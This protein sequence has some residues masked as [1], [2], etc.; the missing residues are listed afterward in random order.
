M[1]VKMTYKKDFPIFQK[2]K[3]LVYLDSAATSQKPKQV[4]DS[5]N[6]FYNDFNANINRGLYD[7]SIQSTEGYE[8][9]REKVAQF[10]GAS[11]DE[12]IFTSGTTDSLNKLARTL[13][14]LFHT[15]SEIVLTEMEHHSNIVPWQETSK[16]NKMKLKFIPLK[17]M[18][19]DYEIAEKIINDKTAIVSLTHLSNSL[20]TINNIEKIIELAKK[21]GA[22]VII[23]AAQSIAHKKIDV[24]KLNCDF[25]VFSGHKMFA[26]T[27]IGIIYGK[28]QI[29]EKLPAFQFGGD[30]IKEVSLEESSYELPPKKFEAGTPNISGAI[31]LGN[32]VE[33]INKIGINKIEKYENELTVYT[34]KELKKIPEIIIYESKNQGP[35]ISFNLDNI[36]H[37]DVASILSY[38]SIAIRAGHHCCMPLMKSLNIPGTCRISIS[39]YNNKEDIDKLIQGI[40]KVKEVFK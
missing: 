9:A 39:I 29:L 8:S 34:I 26:S 36:H 38:E 33:Y 35:I 5:M 12:I 40:K 17:N 11:R 1:C 19:L 32:A 4:I 6:Q 28:K 15:K 2:N 37:H 31:S 10:I 7:L 21:Y 24:K 18:E 23:D 20:G 22:I 14:K 13:P 25:I 30:M 16:E 27:G 3:N